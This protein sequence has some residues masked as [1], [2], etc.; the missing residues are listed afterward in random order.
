MVAHLAFDLTAIAM[1]YWRWEEAVARW[2]F[3]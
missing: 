2:V 1:I 3:R